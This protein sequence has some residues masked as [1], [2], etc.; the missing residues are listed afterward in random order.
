[1]YTG[2]RYQA[3][4][5]ESEVSQDPRAKE[6]LDG[7]SMYAFCLA[8]A[9]ASLDDAQQLDEYARRRQRQ[10][11]VG[12]GRY[13]RPNN[14]P[15]PFGSL[16]IRPVA[17]DKPTRTRSKKVQSLSSYRTVHAVVIA[18]GSPDCSLCSTHPSGDPAVQSGVARD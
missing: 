5:G 2:N 18:P 15:T 1:M 6:I 7:F 9:D 4:E 10:R 16:L 17:A 8:D 11:H 14:V 13:V 3:M 12:V